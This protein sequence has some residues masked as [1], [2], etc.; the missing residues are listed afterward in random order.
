MI[1]EKSCDYELL[2]MLA[3][4]R[5]NKDIASFLNVS[6]PIAKQRLQ[7]LFLELLVT[8]ETAS[9][10]GSSSECRGIKKPQPASAAGAPEPK[11]MLY[12]LPCAKC[13]AY[14]CADLPVCPVCKS[15]DRV[16]PNA[17][18]ALPVISAMTTPD[19]RDTTSRAASSDH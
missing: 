17:T 7:A 2:R 8:K 19:P 16:S 10:A 3:Q 5:S 14:Y 9:V 1:E 12:G 15:S 18:P 6:P 4:G 11:A 13:R